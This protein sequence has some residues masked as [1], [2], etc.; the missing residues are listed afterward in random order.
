MCVSSSPVLFFFQLPLFCYRRIATHEPYGGHWRG[1]G[2]QALR[3]YCL[4]INPNVFK[5]VLIVKKKKKKRFLDGNFQCYKINHYFI[6]D[7]FCERDR[8]VREPSVG[9]L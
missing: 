9:L 1:K 5:L 8:W 4:F 6:L 7:V 3:M 2:D